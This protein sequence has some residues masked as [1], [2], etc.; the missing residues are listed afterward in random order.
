[1]IVKNVRDIFSP[2]LPR[3]KLA[4]SLFMYRVI[5]ENLFTNKHTNTLQ[6]IT[7]K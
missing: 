3:A 6:T 1:M 7:R 2:M 4:R 5:V